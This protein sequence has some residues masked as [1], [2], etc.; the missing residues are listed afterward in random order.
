M[1]SVVA[2]DSRDV[3]QPHIVAVDRQSVSSHPYCVQRLP[4]NVNWS[5]SGKLKLP[6]D[7]TPKPELPLGRAH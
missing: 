4:R 3:G 6:Q 2:V 1:Q 5:F 7:T